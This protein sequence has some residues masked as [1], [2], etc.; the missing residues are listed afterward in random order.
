MQKNSNYFHLFLWILMLST[1]GGIRAAGVE[2][3]TLIVDGNDSIFQSSYNATVLSS[4]SEVYSVFN[5]CAS[6][7]GNFII[8]RDQMQDPSTEYHS[9]NRMAAVRFIN[10]SIPYNSVVQ[11]AK[12]R[13]TGAQARGST[14][15]FSLFTQSS[16]NPSTFST[17]ASCLSNL[18]LS[19]S[20]VPF[21]LDMSTPPTELDGLTPIIQEIVGNQG[22]RRG[23]S[24]VVVAV[25]DDSSQNQDTELVVQFAKRISLEIRYTF[26]QCINV[27]CSQGT[28]CNDTNTSGLPEWECVYNLC[29]LKP[30]ICPLGYSCMDPDPRI[31]SDKK[32]VLCTLDQCTVNNGGCPFDYN[33]TDHDIHNEDGVECWKQFYPND[34]PVQVDNSTTVSVVP[35][36]SPAD[37]NSTSVQPYVSLPFRILVSSNNFTGTNG[38]NEFIF[39]VGPYNETTES[40]QKG[41]TLSQDYPLVIVVD[42]PKLTPPISLFY[43]KGENWLDASSV[44]CGG[45]SVQGST[46]VVT[47]CQTDAVRSF[48]LVSQPSFDGYPFINSYLKAS[49]ASSKGTVSGNFNNIGQTQNTGYWTC[50]S[51]DQSPKF[52]IPTQELK[53]PLVLQRPITGTPGKSFPFPSL[54]AIPYNCSIS[55]TDFS[56]TTIQKFSLRRR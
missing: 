11:G 38:N 22:W 12:L 25:L 19:S 1:M 43:Q 39:T 34:E 48:N 24:I 33:C 13:F 55:L 31:I 6:N 54:D 15:S 49:C 16:P 30:N 51:Y 20:S 35:A 7:N 56:K 17:S 42:L 40:L 21:S 47:V 5:S 45:Y 23:N 2:E 14:L 44:S 9:L 41:M 32:K 50:S 26:D 52:C 18:A 3:K 29:I 8:G 46:L 10:V 37:D 53:S 36:S 4:P 27:T 28:F